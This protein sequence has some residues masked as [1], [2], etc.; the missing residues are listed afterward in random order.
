M[1][2]EVSPGT[3]NSG[4]ATG[5]G[6]KSGPSPAFSARYG[7]GHGSWADFPFIHAQEVARA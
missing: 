1:P 4:A 5:G 6:G 3:M 7:A 2:R